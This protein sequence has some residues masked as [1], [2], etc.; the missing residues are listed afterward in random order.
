MYL[1]TEFV[2]FGNQDRVPILLFI[3]SSMFQI[4]EVIPIL[5]SFNDDLL[6]S[7]ITTTA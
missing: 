2:E 5:L 4:E 3:H 6:I 1:R 7:M